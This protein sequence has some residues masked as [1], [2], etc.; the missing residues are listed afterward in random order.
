MDADNLCDMMIP[1][2]G[3][4][5]SKGEFHARIMLDSGE[6]ID[7]SAYSSMADVVPQFRRGYGVIN[8]G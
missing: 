3:F 6:I 7:F 8:F 5:G 1:G 4:I 2:Y